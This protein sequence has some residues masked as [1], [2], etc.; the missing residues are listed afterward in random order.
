MSEWIRYVDRIPL[1]GQAVLAY[2]GEIFVAEYW[3]HQ[4]ETHD[5]DTGFSIETR[6]RSSQLRTGSRYPDHQLPNALPP[7]YAACR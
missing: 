2:A 5:A 1:Q 4:P 7:I 6:M 3:I